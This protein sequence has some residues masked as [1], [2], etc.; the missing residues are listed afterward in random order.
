ML[1]REGLAF[2]IW[3]ITELSPTSSREVQSFF[4]RLLT[5]FEPLFDG[6]RRSGAG[7]LD[8]L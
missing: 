8:R 4:I 3:Q 6:K 1:D 7:L 5:L 2:W